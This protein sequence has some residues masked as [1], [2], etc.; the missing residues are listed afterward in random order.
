MLVEK[1]RIVSHKPML[2]SAVSEFEPTRQY[3][4]DVIENIAGFLPL[5]VVLGLYFSFT[6]SRSGR[7]FARCLLEVL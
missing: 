4:D 3:V 5:A 6:R 7:F 2:T 1:R